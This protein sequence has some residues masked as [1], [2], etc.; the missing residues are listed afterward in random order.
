[1]KEY[2]KNLTVETVISRLKQGEVLTDGKRTVEL[3]DGLL[4]A[5]R[6]D[7]W[8]INYSIGK[9]FDELYFDRPAPELKLEIGKFYSTRDGKKAYVFAVNSAG[10]YNVA[11]EGEGAYSVFKGGYYSEEEETDGD[12]IELWSEP[13]KTRVNYDEENYNR[14]KELINRGLNMAEIGRTL[15]KNGNTIYAYL[16]YHQDLADIYYSIHGK[17]KNAKH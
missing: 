13:K 17:R 11:I 7:D 10:K 9:E 14:I 2:I 16:Q 3:I 6:N 12:L 5:K 15:N 1:M 8:V 4:V